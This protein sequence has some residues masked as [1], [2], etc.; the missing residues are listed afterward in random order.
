MR[1]KETQSELRNYLFSHGDF[2]GVK[3]AL[4]YI[5]ADQQVK[6]NEEKMINVSV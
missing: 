6:P 5:Y 3:R 4:D 1:L 2:V